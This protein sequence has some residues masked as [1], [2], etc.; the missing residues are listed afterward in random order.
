MASLVLDRP[1]TDAAF[2]AYLA[3]ELGLGTAALAAA[4]G[5]GARPVHRPSEASTPLV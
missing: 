2:W 3:V 1:R 5:P 4:A